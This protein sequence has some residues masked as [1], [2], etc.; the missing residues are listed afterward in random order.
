VELA[1]LLIENPDLGGN[2]SMLEDAA[3]WSR[4]RFNPAFALLVP[5]IADG[6]TRKPI[7][8]QYPVLGFVLADEDLVALQRYVRDHS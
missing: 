4:R 6:R 7:Q 5:H 2:A 8:N 1:R 3:G